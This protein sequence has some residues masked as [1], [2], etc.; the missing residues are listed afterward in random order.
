MEVTRFGKEWAEIAA[1]RAIVWYIYKCGQHGGK[2]TVPMT[3]WE[4]ITGLDFNW[5]GAQYTVDPYLRKRLLQLA[6]FLAPASQI[7]KLHAHS[8]WSLLE[9]FSPKQQLRI[10]EIIYQRYSS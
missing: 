6:F 5:Q 10:V 4:A 2:H 9:Y 3:A 1:A 8:C 7:H